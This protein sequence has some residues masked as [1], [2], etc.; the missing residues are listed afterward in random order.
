MRWSLFCYQPNDA[1]SAQFTL[2]QSALKCA[3]PVLNQEVCPVC[4]QVGCCL[5]DRRR[6]ARVLPH[7]L[8]CVTDTPVTAAG[9]HLPP[10]ARQCRTE[11]VCNQ[12]VHRRVSESVLIAGMSEVTSR[13]AMAQGKGSRG[14]RCPVLLETAQ[15]CPR[16]GA[17]GLGHHGTRHCSFRSSRAQ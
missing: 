16:T 2:Q 1:V 10:G 11:R 13:T 9:L 7:P 15:I 3:P 6:Q 5:G 8:P 17:E 4:T 12:N 14:A